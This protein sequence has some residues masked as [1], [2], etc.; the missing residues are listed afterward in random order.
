MTADLQPSEGAEDWPSPTRR[1]VGELIQRSGLSPVAS[2]EDLRRFQADLW[3][4]EE[5]LEAFLSN[6]R[7][8]R[9]ADA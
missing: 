7:A 8:S 1:T 2:I 6:I 9:A 4:S 3:D 5:D